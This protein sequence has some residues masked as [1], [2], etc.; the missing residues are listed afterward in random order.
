MSTQPQPIARS[1]LGIALGGLVLSATV[2]AIEGALRG[3]ADW[4]ATAFL[5][6]FEPWV[7]LGAPAICLAIEACAVGWQRSA[8]R[9]LLVERLP[10]AVSTSPIWCCC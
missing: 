6:L 7:A 1:L 9:S 5:Q 4:S 2:A 10:S 3:T 8:I